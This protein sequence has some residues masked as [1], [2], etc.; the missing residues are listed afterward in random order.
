MGGWA[1]IRHFR[2]VGF[3]GS[4]RRKDDERLLFAVVFETSFCLGRG[5]SLELDGM[6]F[7]L[8]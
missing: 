6:A 1:W 3:L 5:S 4:P 7:T 2:A 8:L